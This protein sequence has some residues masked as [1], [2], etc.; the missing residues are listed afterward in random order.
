DPPDFA[1]RTNDAVVNLA[2]A[3]PFG[4]HLIAEA[5]HSRQILWVHPGQPFTYRRLV[6]PLGQT[7][8]GRIA[9]RDLQLSRIDVVGIATHKCCGSCECKLGVAFGERLLRTLV[10]SD[11]ARYAEQPYSN[12]PRTAHNGAIDRDPSRLAGMRVVRRGHHSVFNVP[13]A[14]RF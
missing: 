8:N 3:T 1:V 14:P 5:F 7:V 10:L 6:S 12:T 11:I 2:L 4:E 9:R 13:G